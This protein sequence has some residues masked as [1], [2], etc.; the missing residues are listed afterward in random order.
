MSDEKKYTAEEV[1]KKVL[2]KTQE[3]LQKSELLKTN[4]SHEVE[5]GK[6][7]NNDDAECPEYLADA[8]IE[9]SGEKKAKKKDGE[10]SFEDESQPEHEE[11]M[12]PEENEEHDAQENAEDEADAD[13]IEADEEPEKKEL[14][15]EI[16][17]DEA[18]KKDSDEIIDEAASENDKKEKEE[19]KEIEKSEQMAAVKP[20]GGK[21]AYPTSRPDTGYG[22]VIVKKQGVPKGADPEV[23]EKCVKDVKAQGKSKKSAY[24]IC[25]AAGAGT[26][27]S[28]EDNGLSKLRK[29]LEA[30]EDKLEKSMKPTR[31]A[32]PQESTEVA[33]RM[34]YKRMITPKE[35][36]E[37]DEQKKAKN[38]KVEKFLGM[39]S[40]QG[41][42]EKQSLAPKMKEQEKPNGPKGQAGY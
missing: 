33:D 37:L 36:Q 35:R 4:T 8:D 10:E 17:E 18:D 16:E 34:K 15:E 31:M 26:K 19:K 12:S 22:K 14:D 27:K 5:A 6:E 11:Q 9:D 40:K 25:N 2:L 3:M 1:A 24:K 32:T 30:R 38:K 42:S 23:H 29:F 28:E 7:P 13:N 20:Q 41:M 21:A 39:D